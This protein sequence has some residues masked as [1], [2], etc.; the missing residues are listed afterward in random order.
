MGTR[1]LGR[2]SSSI[3]SPSFTSRL[4]VLRIMVRNEVSEGS[5]QEEE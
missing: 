3:S 5:K 1:K 2:M 4:T